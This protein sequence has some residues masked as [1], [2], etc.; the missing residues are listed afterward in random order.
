MK[1][2]LLFIVLFAVSSFGKNIGFTAYVSMETT[3]G[4][5]EPGMDDSVKDLQ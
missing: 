1:K 2:L 3:N 5:K 4:F